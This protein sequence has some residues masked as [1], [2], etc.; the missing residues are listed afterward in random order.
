VTTGMCSAAILGLVL[1]GMVKSDEIIEKQ[2]KDVKERVIDRKIR[3]LL[4]AREHALFY[5]PPGSGKTHLA[6]ELARNESVA[7]AFVKLNDEVY[8]GSS[9]VKHDNLL[10]EAKQILKNQKAEIRTN[11]TKKSR[12]VVIIVDE[13]DEMG[14][15]TFSPSHNGSQPTNNF[16]RMTDTI[17]TK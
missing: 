9:Q 6:H 7:Y 11:P 13:I 12:P 14:V 1:G 4:R 10:R 17:E 2:A 15:K 3:V 16:L 5:G 8:V